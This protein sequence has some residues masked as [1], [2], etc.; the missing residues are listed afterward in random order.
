MD[1]SN[2]LEQTQVFFNCDVTYNGLLNWYESMIE[3][4]GWILLVS[5]TNQKSSKISEY[6]KSIKKLYQ[7]LGCY[8]NQTMNVD[9]KRDI[10]V[11]RRNLSILFGDFLL[12]KN[13]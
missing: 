5:K 10:Q 3:M 9:K 7:K 8:K 1:N 11:M 2:H 12:K 13:S 4:Y 6:L